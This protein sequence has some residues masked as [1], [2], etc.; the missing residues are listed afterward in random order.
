MNLNGYKLVFFE[1]NK[2][3]KVNYK[4]FSHFL[5]QVEYLDVL[6]KKK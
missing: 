4:N 5:K 3:A 6:F 2:S 1:T